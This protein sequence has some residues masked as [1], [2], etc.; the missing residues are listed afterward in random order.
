MQGIGV[1]HKLLDNN[2]GELIREEQDR[3]CGTQAAPEIAHHPKERVLLVRLDGSYYVETVENAA[4]AAS[5]DPDFVVAIPFSRL[6]P[7]INRSVN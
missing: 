4:M 3:L 2:R 1:F 6:R 5:A 7:L